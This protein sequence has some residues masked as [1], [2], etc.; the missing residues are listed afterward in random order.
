MSVQQQQWSRRENELLDIAVEKIVRKA[1]EVG[2]RPEDMLALLDSGCT[3]RD[4]LVLVAAKRKR[5]G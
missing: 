4:L 2:I 3:V 1:E 5:I